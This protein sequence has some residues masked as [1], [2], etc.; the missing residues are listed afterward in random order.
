MKKSLAFVLLLTAIYL[1]SY[2][3]NTE[4]IEVI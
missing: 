2:W 3:I 4:Y 1:M